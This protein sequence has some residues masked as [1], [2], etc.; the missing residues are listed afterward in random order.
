MSSASEQKTGAMFRRA[1]VVTTH[2]DPPNVTEL[3]SRIPSDPRDM[4]SYARSVLP[5][6]IL[7]T[8]PQFSLDLFKFNEQ[9]AFACA[10]MNIAP[11]EVIIVT[12]AYL[13]LQN[14]T[15]TLVREICRKLTT[16]GFVVMDSVNFGVCKHCGEVIVSERRFR[17]GRLQWLGLC[18][19]CHP[20]APRQV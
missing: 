10:K 12:E 19:R 7:G 5:G 3:I 8:A 2:A 20:H 11:Q 14:T 18:Q 1:R 4:V 9:W 17:E 15:H 13:D 16:S 6:W